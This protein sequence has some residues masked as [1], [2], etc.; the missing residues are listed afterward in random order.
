QVRDCTS[1]LMRWAKT[2]NVPMFLVGHV[3]KEGA[4]A[5]PRVLEHIVDV[6]LYLEGERF[7]QYRLLRGAKNRFGSTDEVG[8]FEMTQDGLREVLNPSQVFLAERS[9]GTPGSA[10]AVT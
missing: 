4:I 5:G 8:V 9:V 2:S 6:V 3:T 7:H 1:V 10:V